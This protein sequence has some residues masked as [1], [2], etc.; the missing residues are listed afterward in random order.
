MHDGCNGR[1]ENGA[2]IVDKLR[3]MGFSQF[4]MPL[5]VKIA[6]DSCETVFT[7]QT[8]EGRCNSCGMVY[9][10]TPCHANDPASV[11]PAGIDY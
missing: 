6:C 1:F 9:G 2:L 5:P 3:Q 10:V 7:M 11:Q 8:M 4:A